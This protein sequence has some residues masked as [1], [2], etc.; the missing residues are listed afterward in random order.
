MGNKVHI[1]HRG[2]RETHH[3]ARMPLMWFSLEIVCLFSKAT[4]YICTGDQWWSL[5]KN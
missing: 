2:E 4:T 3:N 1:V 5:N